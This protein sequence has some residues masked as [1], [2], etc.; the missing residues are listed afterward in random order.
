MTYGCKQQA[1]G[2]IGKTFEIEDE[3]Q[4]AKRLTR[5]LLNIYVE[6]SPKKG[7]QVLPAP[8]DGEGK[9]ALTTDNLVA[10]VTRFERWLSADEA[11]ELGFV[12]E[13]R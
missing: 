5:Q 11:L 10:Y 13:V 3:A 4:L 7:E 12:D 2:A 8:W 1:S 6:R 9:V